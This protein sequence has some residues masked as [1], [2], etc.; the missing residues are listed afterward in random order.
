[1]QLE[2]LMAGHASRV[3][4]YIVNPYKNDKYFIVK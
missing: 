3:L 4:T 2:S 1:M